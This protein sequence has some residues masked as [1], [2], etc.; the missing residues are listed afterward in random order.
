MTGFS[1]H[2]ITGCPNVAVHVGNCQGER[3]YIEIRA[4]NSAG[5]SQTVQVWGT[6]EEIMRIDHM[7][8]KEVARC[9]RPEV[10]VGL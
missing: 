7:I 1:S 3:A 10:P 8:H 2:N 4:D 5:E 9:I 6:V